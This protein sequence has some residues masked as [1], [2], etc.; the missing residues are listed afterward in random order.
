VFRS[1]RVKASLLLAGSIAFVVLGAWI[2]RKGHPFG[3]V[4][5]AFFGLGIPIALLLL[6]RP[7]L[8]FLR[9]DPDGFEIRTPFKSYR[10]SWKDVAGFE[11]GSGHGTKLIEIRYGPSYQEQRVL[12][13]I[14][15][16]VSGMEA[17][18]PNQ[19]DSPQATILATLRE[20]HA[21]YGVVA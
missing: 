16:A 7:D 10:V 4:C 14:A 12:R 18:I 8:N 3:W 13:G 6:T 17:A 15:S 2:A 20:F 21:R 1:S 19:Y 9:L 11:I 5:V